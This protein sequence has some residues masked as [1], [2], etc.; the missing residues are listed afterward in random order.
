MGPTL[1]AYPRSPHM[2]WTLTGRLCSRGLPMHF[3][4]VTWTSLHFHCCPNPH[5]SYLWSL[6]A[7][8]WQT[9]FDAWALLHPRGQGHCYERAVVVGSSYVLGWGRVVGSRRECIAF[10]DS[11]VGFP[12]GWQY[13]SGCRVCGRSSWGCCSWGRASRRPPPPCLAPLPCLTS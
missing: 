6:S 4:S 12:I 2:S 1:P 3:I 9:V 8:C 5:F 11:S 7:R 10:G 13:G